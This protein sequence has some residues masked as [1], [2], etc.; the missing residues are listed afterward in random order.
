MPA[1]ICIMSSTGL[2]AFDE[3]AAEKKF[4]NAKNTQESI[5]G[6][7]SWAMQH[8]SHHEKIVEVWLNV[9][10]KCKLSCVP[11]IITEVSI[12]PGYST[13]TGERESRPFREE[14]GTSV[15]I[16]SMALALYFFFGYPCTLHCRH[17]TPVHGQE[18]STC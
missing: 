14:P 12:H 9:L 18:S 7:S 15:P 8:K 10:K 5:Q 16:L 13:S 3:A 6:V 17:A 1:S 4:I 2:K 11:K